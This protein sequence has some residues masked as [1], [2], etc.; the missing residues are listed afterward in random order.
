MVK[1]Y[2]EVLYAH[3]NIETTRLMLRKFRAEDAP[4]VLEIG[5][6]PQTL[7]FLVW[8]GCA[9]IDE[10]KAAIFDYYWSR[11]GIWAIALKDGDVAIGAIDL[12]LDHDNDKAGFGYA[13]N[14][15][16]WGQGYT[17]EALRA[18]LTLC[19]EHLQLNRVEANHYAGNEASGRVMQKAGMTREG[20]RAQSE[21]VKGVFRDTVH[22][23]IIRADYETTPDV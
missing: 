12:R 23:G 6:D 15:K 22:Y 14:R 21:K 8:E 1:N 4:N 19:F 18:V 13:L 9:N 11:P 17:T 20:C 10:A 5:S 2:N 7:E 16:Y 3:E